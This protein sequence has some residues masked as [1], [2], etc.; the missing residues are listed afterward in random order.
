MRTP[1]RTATVFL[2]IACAAGCQTQSN[3]QAPS[4]AAAPQYKVSATIKDL[5]MATVDPLTDVVWESVATIVTPAGTEERRP[6]NDEEWTAV[7]NAAVTVMETAN[8]LQMPGRA[9]ARPGEQSEFPGIELEP[10]EMQ[11]LIDADLKAWSDHANALHDAMA[12]ALKA[13][14]AKDPE[15]VMAAGEHIENAC[16]SCHL[17]YWYP[18]QSIP[19]NRSEL[20]SKPDQ[21]ERR[22]M[23]SRPEPGAAKP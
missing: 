20:R 14:E 16:E 11:K 6:R 19:V 3:E 21:P 22:G 4:A 9:V 2:S 17:K 10:S 13:A 7:K 1:F 18:N 12:D 23:P 5:M 15:G 8:L